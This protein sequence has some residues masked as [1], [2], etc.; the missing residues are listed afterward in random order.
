MAGVRTEAECAAFVFVFV[1]AGH[2]V[3]DVVLDAVS[4]VFVE[5]FGS[6]EVVFENVAAEFDG[7]DLHTE[8]EAKVGDV[9]FACEFGGEDFSF[10]AA[11]A[12]TAR[13]EDAVDFF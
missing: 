2:E 10:G 3:D 9:F 7:H 8:A 13:D 6:D 5:F 1:L 12:K 4:V 11:D